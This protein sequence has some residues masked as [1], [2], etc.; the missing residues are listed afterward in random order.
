M[1]SYIL[2]GVFIDK[3]SYGK[4]S[5]QINSVE[6]TNPTTFNRHIFY[7]KKYWIIN[8][9]VKLHDNTKFNIHLKP[10]TF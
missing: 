1:H 9:P 6:T 10:S 4:Y 3:I 7:S 5:C 8:C 2:Y